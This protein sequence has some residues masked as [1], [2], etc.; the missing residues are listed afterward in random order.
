MMGIREERNV[1]T[2]LRWNHEVWGQGRAELAPELL[3]PTYV[4]HD[5]SGVRAWTPE[6]YGADVA[7]RGGPRIRQDEVLA[8]GDFVGLRWSLVE[9]PAGSP[10]VG[11]LQVYQFD[12]QHRLCA[13][14]GGFRNSSA[15]AWP[16]VRTPSRWL[17]ADGDEVTKA[18]RRNERTLRTALDRRLA[19]DPTGLE[20][21]YL[22]PLPS[23]T[24]LLDRSESTS[25]FAKR[26]ASEERL[27]PGKRFVEHA[28][29]F[30]GDRSVLVWGWRWDDADGPTLNGTR[31][32]SPW[33]FIEIWRYEDGRIAERWQVAAPPGVSWDDT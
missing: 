1:A 26:I 23:H 4:R 28:R 17:I 32:R 2:L 25:D 13:M 9:P 21:L 6:E 29:F 7:S 15:G 16:D 3:A 30:V 20:K 33:E 14:W 10:F 19:N 18:E 27:F 24:P 12:E 22:D 5:P 8:R 31:Y 11:G